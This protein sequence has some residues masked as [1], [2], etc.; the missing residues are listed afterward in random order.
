LVKHFNI[1]SDDLSSV[2]LS[3]FCNSYI[4]NS[5]SC[6]LVCSFKSFND[7]LVF[8]KYYNS[9]HSV[10]VLNITISQAGK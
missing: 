1:C 5:S 10:P 8:D 4:Y 3:K 9:L 6:L 2:D 7:F